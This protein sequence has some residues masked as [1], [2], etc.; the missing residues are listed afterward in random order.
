MSR[1]ERRRPQVGRLL[2]V[3]ASVGAARSEVRQAASVCGVSDVERPPPHHR[4]EAG[5][6]EAVAPLPAESTE[7]LLFGRRVDGAAELEA[8]LLGEAGP[9]WM[10][11]E[12]PRDHGTLCEKVAAT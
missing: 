11:S 1:Q 9:G 8:A 6:S 12:W 3:R 5:G 7:T 10:Y 2:S 4:P